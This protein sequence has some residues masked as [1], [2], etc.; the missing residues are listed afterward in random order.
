MKKLQ[1]LSVMLMVSLAFMTS[2]SSSS[3]NDSVDPQPQPTPVNYGLLSDDQAGEAP[4]VTQ[5]NVTIPNLSAPYVEEGTDG[6]VG[7]IS[8]TGI[9]GIDGNFLSLAGTG[10]TTQNVWMTIDGKAKSIE[11][12][13]AEDITRATTT[14]KGQADIVFLVDNSGSMSEEANKLAEQVLTWSQKLSEVVD[15]RF[16]CVG[17][18][19]NMY[20][21]DGGMDLAE[22]TVLNEFLNRSGK[23][24]TSRTMSFYGDNAQKLSDLALSNVK[25]YYN[26][27]G[28]ECGGLALH[29]ADEQFAWRDGANRIYINFTDEPNQPNSYKQWSVETLNVR[30]DIYNWNA[31]KGTVHSVYSGT[32]TTLY[33]E[34]GSYYNNNKNNPYTRYEKPWAMSEYTGGITLKTDPYF[35][36]FKLDDIEVTGAILSSYILR[37]NITDELRN[38][39]H[40]IT[41]TVKDKNGSEAVKTFKDV[42]FTL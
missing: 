38:G 9:K 24:G 27:S 6:K 30:S 21:I 39:K 26:G 12:V 5:S 31:S 23:T 10:T 4:V 17:Y 28:R 22:I 13:N 33:E 3:S 20:G 42:S 14:K 35:T 7:N 19:A 41:I 29:F 34:G 16:G 15:C 18:G 37:F 11:I 1:S 40:T 32:D 36:S 2:C 8:F 25:G